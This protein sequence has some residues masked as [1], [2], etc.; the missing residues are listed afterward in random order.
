MNSIDLNNID[1]WLKILI[2]ISI[3]FLFLVIRSIYRFFNLQKDLK[4]TH[5]LTLDPKNIHELVQKAGKEYS[6]NLDLE[7]T[8]DL[9]VN[10]LVNSISF[11]SMSFLIPVAEGSSEYIYKTHLIYEVSESFVRENLKFIKEH[12]QNELGINV[13]KV[14]TD[15]EGGPTNSTSGVK[16]LSRLLLPLEVGSLKGVIC[17]TSRKRDHF[18]PQI[19]QDLT[20]LAQSLSDY[21]SVLQKIAKKE[22]EKFKA[23]VDSMKD[24]VFMVDEEYRFLIANPA[25]RE[26]LGLRHNESVNV[27]RVSNF[28]SRYFS[29]EETVSEVFVMGNTKKIED[30]KINEKYYS[31]NAIP[32]KDNNTVQ[33]VVFIL[34]DQTK[35]KELAQMRQDFSA[36]IIHELRSPLSVIRGTSDFIMKEFSN[37]SDEQ[38]LDFLHQ[39]KDSSSTLLDLVNDL[40]DSAKIESGNIQ[41]F[42]EMSNIEEILQDQVD[43]Y[44]RPA[45]QKNINLSSDIEVGLGQVNIDPGKIRQLL[46]N[47][48]SNGIK[49]TPEGGSVKVGAQRTGEGIRIY[50]EDT[51]RGVS[52]ADKDMIFDKYKRLKQGSAE[53]GTGLGLAISKGIVEAHEGRIWVEDNHPQGARFV[54]ELPL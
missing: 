18:P 35:E 43:Y 48:I 44:A 5:S 14:G 10:S 49:Y 9:L 23:M 36:M 19:T 41:L 16:A 11:T 38:K 53:E 30:L 47:L 25:L 46:N 37:M 2:G 50:V 20:S 3:P 33:A 45:E 12:A 8:L 4:K 27:V 13:G 34:E 51:G 6:K 15:I 32:V 24:G 1:L 7:Q 40:L 28:F 17:I 29:V 21:L 42:K 31:L 26:I 52:E 22:H 54:V 39:I